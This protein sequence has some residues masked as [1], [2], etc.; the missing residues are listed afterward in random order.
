MLRFVF[1]NTPLTKGSSFIPATPEEPAAGAPP[2]AAPPAEAPAAEAPAAEAPAA[3]MPAAE[4][5]AAE[6]P[7][8]GNET[9]PANGTGEAAAKEIAHKASPVTLSY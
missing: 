5:P 3:E 6:T 9:A 8:A 7:A 1:P 4:E 2:A